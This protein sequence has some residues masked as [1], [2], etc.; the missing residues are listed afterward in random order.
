MAKSVVK[1]KPSAKKSPAKDSAAKKTSESKS[2]IVDIAA[3]DGEHVE[4]PPPE[5]VEPNPKWIEE[6][7]E[8]ARKDYLLTQFWIPARGFWGKGGARLECLF[9]VAVRGPMFSKC[10]FTYCIKVW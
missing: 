6:E 3:E 7:A 4:P 1:S 10:V 2:E 8:Q 9:G 5:E